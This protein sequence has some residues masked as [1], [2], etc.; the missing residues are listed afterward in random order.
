MKNNAFLELS[1]DELKNKLNSLKEELFNLRFKHAIRQLENP[2]QINVVKKDIAR[3]MTEIRARELGISVAPEKTATK[4]SS[5][6]SSS[7][8]V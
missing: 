7:K 4:K 2:N 3:A 8:N 6:K 5:S 1:N